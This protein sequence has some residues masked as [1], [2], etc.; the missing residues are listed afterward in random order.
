[1][2]IAFGEREDGGADDAIPEVRIEE[3]QHP[4][5]HRPDELTVQSDGEGVLGRRWRVHGFN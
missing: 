4:V 5:W 2:G 3:H 1:V